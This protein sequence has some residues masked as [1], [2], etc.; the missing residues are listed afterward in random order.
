MNGSLPVARRAGVPRNL[1]PPSSCQ[2]L[3]DAHRHPLPLCATSGGC[4]RRG[5]KLKLAGN[6]EKESS[7]HPGL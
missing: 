4:T 6:R 7:R 1:T 3:V 5:P 2:G